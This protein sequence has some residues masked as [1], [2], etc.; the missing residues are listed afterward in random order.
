MV[1][2]HHPGTRQPDGLNFTLVRVIRAQG[3]VFFAMAAIL[4]ASV[5]VHI[6]P[7]R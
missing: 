5:A 1:P 3:T 2:G 6:A 7:M 4:R